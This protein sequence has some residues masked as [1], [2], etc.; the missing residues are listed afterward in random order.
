MRVTLIL[1]EAATSHPDG[2]V[3]MLRAGISRIWYPTEPAPLIAALVA[4]IETDL[5][6]GGTRHGFAIR[7]LNEDGQDMAS[8][9]EG[10]FEAPSGGGAMHVVLGLQ[11]AFPKYGRY[12]FHINVDG[13]RHD[14]WMLDVQ[15][16]P[17]AKKEKS[18]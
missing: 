12:G 1:A 5:S 9:L 18:A 3:S 17:E 16:P 14:T 6:E 2:T 15:P 11:T 13:T 10:H 7:L 4:R 8:K